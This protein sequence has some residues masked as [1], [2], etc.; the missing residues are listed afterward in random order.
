MSDDNVSFASD[1]AGLDESVAIPNQSSKKDAKDPGPTLIVDHIEL[2]N[3][4]SYAGKHRIGP[5]HDTFTAVIGPNGSGK[6]N[7]LDSLLFV[8]GKRA[9]QIRLDKFSELIH[10]SAAHPNCQTAS[11]T[12]V[13]RYGKET[14]RLTREVNRSGNTQY[15]L[16]DRKQPQNTVVTFLKNKGVDLDHNRFLILQGEVEQIALM[17]P[18]AEREGEEGFLEYLDDLIGTN[19]YVDDIKKATVAMEELQEQRV[20]SLE[21]SQKL[22]KERD[23]LESGKNAA[24]SYVRK[25][26][27]M[28]KL[29]S[30]MC[31]LKIADF[32][33][34]LEP[35]RKEIAKLEAEVEKMEE[36]KSEFVAKRNKVDED[37]REEQAT[38]KEQH[39]T[40][41][42]LLEKKKGISKET[43]ILTQSLA[44]NESMRKKDADEIKKLKDQR[45][46]V[47]MQCDDVARDRKIAEQRL[48][49]S[50]EVRNRLEPELDKRTETLQE[51]MRPQ[52]AAMD[53]KRREMAP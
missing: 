47:S 35:Q 25:E 30:T 50:T 40:R 11:V 19:K 33:K 37:L 43:T 1:A 15:Y 16:N 52:Q 48:K 45:Q 31:Q 49:E 23:L 9:K 4:K 12:V 13:F 53:A 17:K 36:S 24:V 51:K 3:F 2:E 20:V 26:N 8:F 22:G 18:K 14:I 32:E 34:E 42:A 6:S 7:I 28:N 21:R 10:N 29:V 27:Q 44:D 41:E 39:K 38:G 46:K 5:F